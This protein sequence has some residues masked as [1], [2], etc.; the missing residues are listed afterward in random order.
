MDDRPNDGSSALL[1]IRLQERD[2]LFWLNE[3]QKQ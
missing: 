1:K 3:N 2:G